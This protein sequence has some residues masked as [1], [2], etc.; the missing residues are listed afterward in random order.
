MKHNPCPSCDAA[1]INGHFCHE[2]G[3]LDSHLN[4]LTECRWCGSE[5]QATERGQKFCDDSCSASFHGPQDVVHE[6]DLKCPWERY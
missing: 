3:C 6:D 2:A 1:V 4:V 5:F